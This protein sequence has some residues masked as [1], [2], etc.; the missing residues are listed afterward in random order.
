ML[1]RAYERFCALNAQIQSDDEL[2]DLMHRL[3][4]ESEALEQLLDRLSPED[5]SIITEYLGICG[6]INERIVEIAAFA[7]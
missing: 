7:M 3:H 4:T 1:E 6:E 5:S 2:Y